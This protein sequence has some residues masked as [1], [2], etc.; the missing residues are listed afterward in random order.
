MFPTSYWSLYLELAAAYVEKLEGGLIHYN[1]DDNL[2]I[3]CQ[4][5]IIQACKKK[6]FIL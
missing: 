1:Y 3:Q 5:E 2:Y 4:N 6:V